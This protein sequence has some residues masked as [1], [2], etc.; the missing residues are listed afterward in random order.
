MKKKKLT[1][2]SGEVRELTRRDIKKF[3]PAGEVLPTALLEV[4]PRRKR[5]QRGTQKMPT[6]ESVT[7]R[8][9]REVLEYFRSTGA[10][11]QSRID[12]ALREWVAQHRP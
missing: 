3:R 11:W 10:G 12:E 1:D 2:K 5:G 9:S 4:L 7:V 6:K 8:Y